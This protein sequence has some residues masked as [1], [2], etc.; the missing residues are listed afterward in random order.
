M[1]LLT[2]AQMK[3]VDRRTSEV[4][5]VPSLTLMEN[6]G[7][8]VAA[9]AEEKFPGLAS[10]PIV[11]L[12]GKGN[13]GGDGLVA[14]RCLRQRGASP[15]VFLFAAPDAVK[16][17]AAVNLKRWQECGGKVRS[18]ASE[19]DWE[20]ARSVLAGARVVL[21]ALL[22]TGLAG[23]A[24]GLMAAVIEDVNR[25][26][27][28]A[29]VISVDVPSGLSSD[30]GHVPG[31]A[32]RA[33]AT[34][35]LCAPKVGMALPPACDFVGE[36]RV[37]PI[38][39]P[40][41]LLEDE[42]L[43]LHLLEPGE[44]GWL[45]RARKPGAHKGDFGHALIIA[46]SRG[47]AGAA[48]LA[49][50]G[51][52]RSGAGLVTVASPSTVQPMVAA[53][54]PELMTEALWPTESDTISARNLDYAQFETLLAG[55]SV[56]ALGPGLTTHPETQQ[57]VRAALE[58][59][60]LPVI[61]DA[62]GLNAFAG[63]AAELRARK[64][65]RL[66][67]TPHPGEMAR[68]LGCASKDVQADRLSVAPRAAAEWNACV[69][70]KGQRTIVAMPDGRAFINPTG[71]P[72]MA[73]GGTGDVLTGMLAGLTAQFGA[74]AWQ[75]ALC[76]GV[77]LHGLAGDLAAARLGEE[78]MLAGDLLDS[79]SSAFARLRADQAHG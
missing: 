63:S 22:G 23:P 55:K 52:L 33:G 67:V 5:G 45:P 1:K 32:V 61:L 73:S 21:D 7:A 40:A 19:A 30:S 54:R 51:A 79:I 62:D 18:V 27:P 43:N 24:T 9:F 72:G 11:I 8:G 56:L 74:E 38:G 70:L 44:F 28:R 36:M 25:M 46:G 2:A 37:V 60:T 39:T 65:P 77:Y 64:A 58:R 59:C 26:A 66:A 78:A 47:K 42:S 69:V 12:C 75:R 76:L 16:G 13:N 34:V 35:T 4:F 41:A 3:E 53:G 15:E 14:A 17:D 50:M 31:P 71:N 10:L 20:Q 48:V 57:F 6:A 49:G 29:A 68:L